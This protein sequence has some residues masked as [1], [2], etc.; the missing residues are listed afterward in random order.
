MI[1]HQL[2][3]DQYYRIII[4][5]NPAMPWKLLKKIYLIF[6]LFILMI[7]IILTIINL[8][9]AIPFYGAEVALLGYALYIT[10]I[11]SVYYEEILIDENHIKLSFVQRKNIKDYNFVRQ[12]TYFGYQKATRT[13]PSEISIHHK[14]KKILIGQRVNEADKK[15]LINLLKT[16]QIRLV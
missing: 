3:K 13:R 7:A 15:E 1:E 14:G 8:Y 2:I 12:W 4:K 10:S 11:K 5:P 6:A 16:F 9:L